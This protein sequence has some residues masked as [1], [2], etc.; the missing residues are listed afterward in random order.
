MDTWFFKELGISPD[1]NLLDDMFEYELACP[2]GVHEAEED[3]DEAED[4]EQAAN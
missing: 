4:D 1:V 2:E 3:S